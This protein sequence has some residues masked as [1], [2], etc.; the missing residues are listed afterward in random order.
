MPYTNIS[1]NFH[2]TLIKIKYLKHE[3][4]FLVIEN[5]ETPNR[6][7]PQNLGQR[8]TQESAHRELPHSVLNST[9]TAPKTRLFPH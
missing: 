1:L 6:E 2:Y 8:E 9:A 5:A 3:W 7:N 4:I